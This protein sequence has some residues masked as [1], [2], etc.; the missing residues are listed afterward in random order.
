MV[1]KDNLINLIKFHVEQNEI[2]F[3]KEAKI[4]SKEFEKSGDTELAIYI[5]SLIRATPAWVPQESQGEDIQTFFFEKVGLPTSP[6]YLPKTLQKDFFGVGNAIQRNMGVNRFLFYGEPGTGKTEAAKELARL[7]KRPLYS[8]DFQTLI[9]SKLGQSAQNLKEAFREMLRLH[10][11]CRPIFLLD[12]LD[13]LVMDRTNS[14]D[15]REMGRLTSTF[16]KEMD[17]LD[18]S[19]CLIA[20]TNLYKHM[21][22]A[23]VRRFD[24]KINFNQYSDEDAIEIAQAIYEN[25]I[26]SL[27]ISGKNV[28]LL[29]KIVALFS[30]APSP[31]VLRNFIRTSIAFSDLNNDSSHLRIL[32]NSLSEHYEK[33]FSIEELSS[34]NFTLRELEI[35]FEESRSQIS[36]NLKTNKTS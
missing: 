4:I 15:L 9:D 8:L 23:L 13:A 29:K 1:T 25:Q 17:G 7:L 34:K 12:E 10:T 32:L 30:P 24:A 35:L 19:I 16:L 6:L 28:R 27:K 18:P 31:G 36:R 22:K 14:N 20:T 21:D 11:F 26:N 3:I 2:S 5:L 33:F